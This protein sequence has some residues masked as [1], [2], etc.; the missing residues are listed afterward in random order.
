MTN[1]LTK[2]AGIALILG[3]LISI[4]RVLPIVLSDGVTGDNFPPESLEDVVFFS[5]LQGWHISHVLILVLIPLLIFGVA[6]FA[7]D[8]AENGQASAGIMALIGLTLSMVLFSVATVLDGFVLPAVTADIGE[9]ALTGDSHSGAL[10]L[11]THEAASIFG[12]TASALLLITALFIGIAL[13][14][15]LG[16]QWLGGLGVVLGILSTLGYLIGVLNLNISDGFSRVGPLLML[17]FF[18]LLAVGIA[19]VRRGSTTTT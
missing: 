19:M 8:A 9:A 10:A 2:K 14:H 3:A 17:I 7:R 11:F 6:V 5:Q 4:F 1:E 16:A 12:G 15:G 13:L 18:Y